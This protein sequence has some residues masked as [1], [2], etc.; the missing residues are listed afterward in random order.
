MCLPRKAVRQRSRLLRAA[1]R[2]LRPMMKSANARYEDKKVD[3]KKRK[4]LEAAGWRFGDYADFLGLTEQERQEV[5]LRGALSRTIRQRREA[6]GMTQKQLA[7]RLK[8]SQSR[9]AKLE[10]GVGVS[11]D[12]LFRVL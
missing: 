8:S 7:E 6:L 10:I 9:V 1:N 4:A 3:P 12:L 2:V 5:E 11:L